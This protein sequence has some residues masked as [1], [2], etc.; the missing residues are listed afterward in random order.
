LQVRTTL[1]A[2]DLKSERS[3]VRLRPFAAADPALRADGTWRV[4]E[5]GDRQGSD[6]PASTEPAAFLN[7]VLAL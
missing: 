2:V 4:V 5:L 7:A 6:R 3:A 1:S